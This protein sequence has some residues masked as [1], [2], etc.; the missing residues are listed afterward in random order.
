[1]LIWFRMKNLEPRYQKL[2]IVCQNE[3][4]DGRTCCKARSEADLFF[5][6]KKAA[7]AHNPLVR[8]IKSSCL[9]ACEDGTTVVVMPA[10]TWYGHVRIADI[11]GIIEEI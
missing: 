10:N 3:R 7:A 5:E 2:L 4:D 6:L 11:P 8:V 9:N 1:M